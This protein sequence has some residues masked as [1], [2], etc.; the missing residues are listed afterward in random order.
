MTSKTKVVVRC[1]DGR[2]VKGYTFDFNP[3]KEA[4]HVIDAYEFPCL[5]PSASWF[6]EAFYG[7]QLPATYDHRPSMLQDL[8]AGKRTEIDALNGAIVR[9]AAE[10]DLAAPA[11]QTMVHLIRFLEEDALRSRAGA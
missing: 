11:N 4:F 7:Q 1:Q 9:L 8:K 3:A 6:R 2:L 10:R 5:W